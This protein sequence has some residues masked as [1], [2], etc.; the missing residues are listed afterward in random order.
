MPLF[1]QDCGD[2]ER[3]PRAAAECVIPAYVSPTSSDR[4]AKADGSATDV[5]GPQS[6]LARPAKAQHG[7]FQSR[8][9]VVRAGRRL[10]TRR[11]YPF[12]RGASV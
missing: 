8:L 10:W 12:F 1:S 3:G 4:G 7:A 9:W 11:L 6:R 5:Q 2:R